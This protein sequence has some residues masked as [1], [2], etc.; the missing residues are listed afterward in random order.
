MP[1][2]QEDVTSKAGEPRAAHGDSAPEFGFLRDFASLEEFLAFACIEVAGS[3]VPL[4]L[5]DSSL[6]AREADL[7]AREEA[8]RANEKM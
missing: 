6:S 5:A 4:P 3:E 1:P 7:A 8:V 2:S